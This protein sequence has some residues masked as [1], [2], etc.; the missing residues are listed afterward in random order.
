MN[1]NK[2]ALALGT[3]AV[4]AC[5]HASSAD[6]TCTRPDI[7]NAKRTGCETELFE[8]DIRFSIRIR[9]RRCLSGHGM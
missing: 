3:I 6:K 7:A 5:A 2:M 1:N 9:S 8:I 4:F